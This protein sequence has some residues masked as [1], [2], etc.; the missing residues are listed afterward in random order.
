[1]LTHN[2]GHRRVAAPAPDGVELIRRSGAAHDWLTA[3]N[4]SGQPAAVPATGVDLRTGEPVIGAALVPPGGFAV[5]R[6]D[7]R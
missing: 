1:L 2:R 5:I 4:H 3:I 7:R 6:T